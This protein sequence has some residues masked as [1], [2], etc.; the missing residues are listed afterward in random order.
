[1]EYCFKCYRISSMSF[2]F[3]AIKFY[4][5]A[6]QLVPDIE[7]KIQNITGFEGAWN[8]AFSFSPVWPLV[9]SGHKNLT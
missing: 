1:M 5:Q 8:T 3:L 9:D 7:N 6:V 2:V 4:R